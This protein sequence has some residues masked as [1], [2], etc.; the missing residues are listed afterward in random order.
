[1]SSRRC[2]CSFVHR[3][4]SNFV[5]RCIVMQVA[6]IF[7]QLMWLLSFTACVAGLVPAVVVMFVAAA[8]LV[9]RLSTCRRNQKAQFITTNGWSSNTSISASHVHRGTADDLSGISAKP[10][11]SLSASDILDSCTTCQ[12]TSTSATPTTGHTTHTEFCTALVTFGTEHCR[13]LL[14]LSPLQ[15]EGTFRLIPAP[16]WQEVAIPADRVCIAQTSGGQDWMLG[17]GSYGKVS[18]A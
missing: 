15:A 1:M 5:I 16:L 2:H 10:Q 11:N 7:L 4:S 9:L 18:C 6:H 14:P 3:L 12:L 17:Q 13:S 8:L